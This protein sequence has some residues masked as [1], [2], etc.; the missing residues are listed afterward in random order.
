MQLAAERFCD[1][2]ISEIRSDIFLKLITFVIISKAYQNMHL[3]LKS[4]KCRVRD[5]KKN[6]VK[7]PCTRL[8]SKASSQRIKVKNKILKN[9]RKIKVFW[10]LRKK[11][12]KNGEKNG[13][14]MNFFFLG[15]KKS[16]TNNFSSHFG[17]I[18]PKG[19]LRPFKHVDRF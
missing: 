6:S 11:I 4:Q 8:E 1:K 13:F 16:K 12:R 9:Y 2:H 14:F 10:C 3:R 17:F 15:K 18:W 19:I 7:L 5:K